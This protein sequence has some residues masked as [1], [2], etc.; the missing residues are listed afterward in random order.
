MYL[1]PKSSSEIIHFRKKKSVDE[2]KRQTFFLTI[3]HMSTLPKGMKEKTHKK[4]FI[5][6]KMGTFK[7]IIC[8]YQWKNN[9]RTLK[10]K[11]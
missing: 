7:A 11:S 6:M 3:T 9:L 10:I 8:I 1:S 4:H 5:F 2:L